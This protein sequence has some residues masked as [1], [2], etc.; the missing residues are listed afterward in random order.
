[1]PEEKF[2]LPGSSYEELVKIIKAYGHMNA[3]SAP[4]EVG[5]LAG[6][7]MTIVSRNN[8]FLVAIGVIEGGKKKVIT[9]KGKALGDALEHELADEIAQNWHEIV[10][11]NEFLQKVLSAVKIRKGMEQSTLQSHIAYS[12]GQ[13]KNQYVMAGASAVI[14]ILKGA[15]SLKEE[16]GKLVAV[17][18]DQTTVPDQPA[19]PPTGTPQAT[20][21][22]PSGPGPS[23][24]R[25]FVAPTGQ[26]GVSISFQIQIQCSPDDVESLA[27]KLRSLLKEISEFGV[28]SNPK[29]DE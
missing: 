20:T 10:M 23:V 14:D 9:S 15:K 4:G 6:T 7:H 11:G 19:Q 28:T 27:P 25:T 2:R 8:A 18:S 21:Q 3:P 22:S 5:R 17:V 13:P 1:M 26:A 16:D 12:A 24:A 29:I